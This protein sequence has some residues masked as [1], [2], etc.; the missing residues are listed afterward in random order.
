MKKKFIQN[1]FHLFVIFSFFVV[2]NHITAIASSPTDIDLIR[3]FDKIRIIDTK[4]HQVCA[5]VYNHGQGSPLEKDIVSGERVDNI[6]SYYG[7]PCS[8]DINTENPLPR[9]LIPSVKRISISRITTEGDGSQGVLSDKFVSLDGRVLVAKPHGN[10]AEHGAWQ[11]L[12]GRVFIDVEYEIKHSFEEALSLIER[13]IT[14]NQELSRIIQSNK[15]A[16]IKGIEELL[17]KAH[18]M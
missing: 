1:I 18:T 4:I 3:E 11:W 16:T 13:L 12:N 8:A 9:E 14:R 15:E 7:G 10:T 5:R 2:G 6:A 17:Q